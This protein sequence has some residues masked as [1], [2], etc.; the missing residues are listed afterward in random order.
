ML[1]TLA[2]MNPVLEAAHPVATLKVFCG[3]DP[4]LMHCMLMGYEWDAGEEAPET[5]AMAFNME[6]SVT[7][8]RTS[9]IVI[10]VERIDIETIAHEIRH[11]YMWHL[12]DL[13]GAFCLNLMDGKTE[14]E[15]NSSIDILTRRAVVGL[16]KSLG[17]TLE[18]VQGGV[19]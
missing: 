11:A 19:K 4:F 5:R 7:G 8:E 1:A 10:N 9:E 15:F 17:V 16:E 3:V 6:C 2:L 12:C 14:E 18:Y 13:N